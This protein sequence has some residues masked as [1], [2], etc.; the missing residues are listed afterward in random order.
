MHGLKYFFDLLLM[1]PGLSVMDSSGCGMILGAPFRERSVA[2]AR[3]LIQ[4]FFVS[5]V[6][7]LRILVLLKVICV[8]GLLLIHF[9]QL[10]VRHNNFDGH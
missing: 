3:Q 4:R 2:R 9:F 10:V 6:S 7:S 1:P 8:R 5:M